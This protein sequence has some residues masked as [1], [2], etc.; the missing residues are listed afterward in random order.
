M[1]STMSGAGDR[2]SSEK[3]TQTRAITNTPLQGESLAGLL[4]PYICSILEHCINGLIQCELFLSAFSALQHGGSR[5]L[6]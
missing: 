5:A 1:L 4:P 6:Q 2:T 3:H